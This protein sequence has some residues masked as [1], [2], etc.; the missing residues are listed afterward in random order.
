MK[1]KKKPTNV[2]EEV[3]MGNFEIFKKLLGLKKLCMV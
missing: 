2:E 3:N 1:K